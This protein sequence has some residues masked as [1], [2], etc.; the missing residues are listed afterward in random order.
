MIHLDCLR[1]SRCRSLLPPVHALCPA[2]SSD[3][4]SLD[5]RTYPLATALSVRS[6]R[7]PRFH[8]H[9]RSPPL[10]FR[11]SHLLL[12]HG[13]PDNARP[14]RPWPPSSSPTSSLPET[15]QSLPLSAKRTG[16]GAVAAKGREA[17]IGWFSSAS[18]A[19]TALPS[20]LSCS[21][22]PRRVHIQ[23]TGCIFLPFR[24]VRH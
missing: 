14:L 11:R 10:L 13:L 7:S 20:L 3:S 22:H 17:G 1:G 4:S 18:S 2:S 23:L 12:F 5:H 6:C 21:S 8:A 15:G 9:T 19:S 24:Q 16:A